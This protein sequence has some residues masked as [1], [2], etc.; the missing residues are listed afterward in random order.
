MAK[1][2]TST[3]AQAATP[4]PATEKDVRDRVFKEHAGAV[5]RVTMTSALWR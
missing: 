4:E 1:K 3:K 5:R 2:R